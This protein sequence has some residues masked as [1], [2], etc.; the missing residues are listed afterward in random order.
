[1]KRLL[2]IA[3]IV[4]TVVLL[5][6]LFAFAVPV[7][8]ASLA[9]S[10]VGIPLVATNQL[11][12]ANP[13]PGPVAFSPN[14]ATD[15]TIFAAVNDIQTA[16]ARPL[17][18]RSLDGGYTWIPTST[19]LGAAAL[20]IIVDLEVS[21][22][23]AADRTVFIATQTPA[24]GAGTGIVY[25]ST[26]GGA[27]FSQLGVVTLGAAE[28]ITSMSVT[29]NYDGVGVIAIGIADTATAT[30]P[31]TAATCVQLWGANGV[32]NWTNAGPAASIDVLALQYSPNFPI[33]ATLLVV[34]SVAV[35]P[36]TLFD[37]VGGVW[38]IISAAGVAV[39]AAASIDFDSLAGGATTNVLAADI[40]LPSDY[41][42]TTPTLRRAYVS[43]ASEAT[44][45]TN[46]Y[47]IDNVTA[48]VATNPGVALA[49]LDYAGT[50]AA[51]TLMGGLITTVAGA[52]NVYYSTTVMTT[53][54][55]WYPATNAPTGASIAAVLPPAGLNMTSMAHIDMASD[56]ATSLMVV[57]GTAGNDSAVAISKDAGVNWNERGLI[58]N[59]GLA[60]T[61]VAGSTIEASPNFATDQTMFMT[62]TNLSAAAT[63]TNV[64][65]TIDAG[66]HWDRVLTDNF[67]AGAFATPGVGVVAISQQYATNSTVYVGDTTTVNL[68]YSNNKGDG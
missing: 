14:F 48:G 33:D 8:A 9:W 29:P 6:S 37:N 49:D 11:F 40:A 21:P 7:S 17:V 38:N 68:L 46:V 63:T 12:A 39:G 64:W 19:V 59:A 41:N 61:F 67:P 43:I 58:D 57:A 50:Y 22:N 42:G 36:P 30:V 34:G 47:R 53:A 56:F 5:A 20:D 52:L 45:S 2:K 62:S 54:P 10:G 44:G 35:G 4:L 18:Y 23:Y 26:N 13:D 65:R 16:L 3:G 1:M 27:T 66:A 25:R 24:G 32:L 60:I 51:G 28:V 31:A 15:N 55:V